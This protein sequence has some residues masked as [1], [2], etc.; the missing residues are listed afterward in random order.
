M[1]KLQGIWNSP[2]P[3]SSKLIVFKTL[4]MPVLVYSAGTWTL[5]DKETKHLD[6]QVHRMRR[7]VCGVSSWMARRAHVCILYTKVTTESAR[8]RELREHNW[9]VIWFVIHV[10]IHMLL[11]GDIM[12]KANSPLLLNN[13]QG[14]RIF[15]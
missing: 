11:C 7:W 2:L 9:L 13:A 10:S 5:T 3:I 8:H 1:N 12:R 4:V 14:T 15:S 6:T